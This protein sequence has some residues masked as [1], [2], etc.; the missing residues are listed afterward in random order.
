MPASVVVPTLSPL[1][2]LVGA[3]GE[4][5]LL[6]WGMPRLARRVHPATATWCVGL[7]AVGSAVA[8]VVTAGA[9]LLSVALQLTPAHDLPVDLVDVPPGVLSSV[10]LVVVPVLAAICAVA[11][12]AA[13]HVRDRVLARAAWAAV[14]APGGVVVVP[15][16]APE[17]YSLPV[18]QGLVILHRGMLD[19]LEP[20]ERDV[21]LAHERA[22]LSRRHHLHVQVTHAAACVNPLLRPLAR[23]SAQQVE[24]WADEVAAASVADRA[25]TA[26]AVARAGLARHSAGQTQPA[27]RSLGLGVVA[28]GDTV[29]RVRA[30]TAP[31]LPERRPLLAG[32]AVLA[33]LLVALSVAQVAPV[34]DRYEQLRHAPVLVQE[35]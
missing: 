31:P 33:L 16:D 12:T 24:R 19:A 20:R 13:L 35:R 4:A 14:R 22:H 25:T 26:R 3:L 34:E 11:P 7:L 28:S 1:L 32:C 21:V 18:H 15:D 8:T 2:G 23:T 6:S 17:A 5:R 29:L 10:L 27:R 30:L 9:V